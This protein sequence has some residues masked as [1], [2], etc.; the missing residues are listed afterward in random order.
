MIGGLDQVYLLQHGTPEQIR[1]EVFRLFEGY[2][3]DGGYIMM[4]CDHFFHVPVEN[5][6]AYAAAARECA[7]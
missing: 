5:L 6:R 3:K 7:Y 1:K 2:G 4:A